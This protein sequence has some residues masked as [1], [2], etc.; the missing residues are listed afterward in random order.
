MLAA[1]RLRAES[2]GLTGIR[3]VPGRAEDLPDLGIGPCRLVTFGQSYHWTAG[4]PVLD[5]AHH[6]LEPGAPSH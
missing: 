4:V 5:A 3:W 2:A 1:G 6:L